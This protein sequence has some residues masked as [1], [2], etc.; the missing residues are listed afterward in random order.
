MATLASSSALRML[1]ISCLKPCE[2]A[3]TFPGEPLNILWIVPVLSVSVSWI[4]WLGVSHSL[5]S[6]ILGGHMWQ[7]VILPQCISSLHEF[8]ASPLWSCLKSSVCV[9][10]LELWMSFSVCVH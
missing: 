8:G 1:N 10:Q 9:L 5:I 2:W 6:R 3:C 7:L 4:G